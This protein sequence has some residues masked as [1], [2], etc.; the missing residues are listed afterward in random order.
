MFGSKR[1]KAENLLA[2][3]RR[4]VGTIV[5]VVDTGMTVNDNP[6]V[7]MTFHVQPLDGS[8]AFEASKTKTV[9][10]VQIPQ[11]GQRYPVWFDAADPSSFAYATV[12]DA[13]G[14]A[15]IVAMFGDAFGPDGSGIGMVA[16]A[17]PAATPAPTATDIADRIRQL[18]ALKAAGVVDDAEYADQKARILRSL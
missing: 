5:G 1:K 11:P 4:A 12:D 17:A 13:N 8:A 9:S 6:R 7:K 14:R 15:Q 3:G 18:D 2:T 10:R 16:P